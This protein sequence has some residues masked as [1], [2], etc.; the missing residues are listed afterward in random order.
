MKKRRIYLKDWFEIKPYDSQTNSDSFYL[1][2]CNKVYVALQ[3]SG[4]ISFLNNFLDEE[5]LKNFSCFLTSY[6]E[7]LVSETR[8]WGTFT[9]AHLSLY[10][11]P[12]PFFLFDEYYEDEVNPQDIAFLTWYYLNELTE[13]T[14]IS[15]YHEGIATITEFVLDI[16]DDA[17]ELAPENKV[18]QSLYKID[19]DETDYYVARKLIDRILFETYLFYPDTAFKLSDEVLDIVETEFM[20]TDKMVSLLNDVRDNLLQI[21]HTRL[22]SFTGKEWAAKLLGDEHA[23]HKDLLN[24]SQK[25][26]GLFLYKGQ[27]DNSIFVEHIASGKSFDITKLSFDDHATLTELDQ[28]IFLG[29]VRW[30]E[31][32]WFSGVSFLSEFNADLILNEKNSITSRM[33]VNFLDEEKVKGEVTLAMQL[34]AFKEYNNGSQIKFLPPEEIDSFPQAFTEYFNKTLNLSLNEE[35]EARERVRKDGFLGGETT[36]ENFEPPTEPGLVFFNPKRG[37]EVAVGINSA[38]PMPNNPFFDAEK[39]DSDLVALLM[40]DY[41][42]KDLAMFCIDNC[43][44]DLSF[45]NDGVG[46]MYMENIDFLMRYW[47]NVNYH[48]SPGITSIS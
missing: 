33:V 13:N 32:W 1:K 45:L 43:K 5:D 25:I 20:D 46:S 11:K 17:W 15:P 26:N 3:E 8:I 18:L 47:K 16:F 29:I 40:N 19:E 21:S 41:F 31:E 27:D 48:A 10:N 28:I 7:D 24:I 2:I 35:E 34:K 30:K 6:L 37:I 12:L 23:L 9:K 42:S 4:E 14:F 36:H 39:T 22:L 44:K 38:F